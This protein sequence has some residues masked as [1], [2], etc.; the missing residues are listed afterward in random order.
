MLALIRHFCRDTSAIALIYVS[1]GLPVFFGVTA[2]AVDG[3]YLYYLKTRAQAAADASALRGAAFYD[4]T[5]EAATKSEAIKAGF[6]NMPPDRFNITMTS[7][8][9]ELGR[10]TRLPFPNTGFTTVGSP[11]NAVRSTVSMSGSS[12]VQLFFA[13]TFGFASVDILAEAVAVQ[14]GGTQDACILALNGSAAQSFQ[15]TGNSNLTLLDCGVQVNSTDSKAATKASGASLNVELFGLNNDF[16]VAGTCDGC[17]AI[18]SGTG[19]PAVN[20]WTGTDPGNPGTMEN[21][22]FSH[23]DGRITPDPFGNLSPDPM[24]M[25]WTM[26]YG[27]VSTSGAWTTN[28]SMGINPATSTPWGSGDLTGSDKVTNGSTVQPGVYTNVSVS[29]TA[30]TVTFAPGVYV[31]DGGTLDFSNSDVNAEGVTF[32]LVNGADFTMSGNGELNLVAPDDADAEPAKS[33]AGFVIYE[34]PDGASSSTNKL[35]GTG[36]SIVSGAVYT[37]QSKVTFA[38][39]VN[40]GS[41][42]SDCFMVVSNQL[43]F[44]G[45]GGSTSN[46]TFSAEG[47]A[48][49]GDSALNSDKIVSLV[50]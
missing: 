33:F 22:S 5:N 7:S 16:N 43:E 39:N 41:A 48:G 12:K 18:N 29:S 49:F 47:C 20:A 34:V 24:E 28:S 27:S 50:E 11:Y 3:A 32:V 4:G 46:I 26:G 23:Q 1:L 6:N 15:V 30:S 2:L 21:P 37:P 14:S 44:L 8:N 10:W 35:S 17:D 31:I 38:G 9:I 19:L 42:V 40:S 25:L 45:G 13:R 36:D